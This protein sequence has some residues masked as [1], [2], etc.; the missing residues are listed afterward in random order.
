VERHLASGERARAGAG[1]GTVSARYSWAHLHAQQ[2]LWN[3]AT[4]LSQD[5]TMDQEK[6]HEKLKKNFHREKREETL[7]SRIPLPG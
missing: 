2:W 5:L 1:G 6:L 3:R 4:S 7:K